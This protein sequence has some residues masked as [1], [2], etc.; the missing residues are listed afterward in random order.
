MTTYGF[1]VVI[2][3]DEDAQGR[4]AWF[5][6]CPAFESIGGATSGLTKEDALRSINEVVRVIVQDFIEEG[7]ALPKGPLPTV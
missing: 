6:Y 2:E 4:P 1:K 7:K 5:A 3:P